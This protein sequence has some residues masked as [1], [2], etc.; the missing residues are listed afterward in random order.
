M[1]WC[2]GLIFLVIA[3]CG[4]SSSE[5]PPPQ[6]PGRA[7]LLRVELQRRAEIEEAEKSARARG[8]VTDLPQFDKEAEPARETWGGSDVKLK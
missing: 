6:P 7:E 1:R 3:G 8:R 5:T 2:Y 4:G